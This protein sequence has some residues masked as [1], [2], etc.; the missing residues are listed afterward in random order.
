MASKK[1]GGEMPPIV[2]LRRRVEG[3]GKRKTTIFTVRLRGFP[4]L[5][6]DF[7]TLT[8][9]IKFRGHAEDRFEVLF[10]FIQ[11]ERWRERVAVAWAAMVESEGHERRVGSE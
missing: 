7:D 3:R 4:P 10:Y 11:P 1:P 9:F 6:V 8:S 2:G 5:E